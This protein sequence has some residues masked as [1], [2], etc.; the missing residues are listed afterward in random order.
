MASRLE[1]LSGTQS[2]RTLA[3]DGRL[4]LIAEAAYQLDEILA[5]DPKKRW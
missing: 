1:A 5:S 4:R 3:L 2:N